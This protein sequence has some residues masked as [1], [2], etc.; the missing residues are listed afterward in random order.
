MGYS[1]LDYGHLDLGRD[2]C[3]AALVSCLSVLT[4]SCQ[5]ATHHP[6]PTA[7]EQAAL[8]G[9][10]KQ[11][12]AARRG[13]ARRETGPVGERATEG[14]ECHASVRQPIDVD[15]NQRPGENEICPFGRKGPV[16]AEGGRWR[17]VTTRPTQV[18]SGGGAGPRRSRGW[19][20][21]HLAWGTRFAAEKKGRS[22]KGKKGKVFPRGMG[23]LLRSAAA[24]RK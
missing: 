17:Q 12:R 4:P 20:F 7:T 16:G 10:T 14:R 11:A 23:R 19:L 1:P 13:E 8:I 21:P 22:E 6:T 15:A 3:H 2:A 9:P 18:E 5:P 24:H